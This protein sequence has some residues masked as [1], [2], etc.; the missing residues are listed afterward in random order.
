MNRRRQPRTRQRLRVRVEPGTINTVTGDLSPGGAFVYS[1]RMLQPGT[2]VRFEVELPGGVA[3][4]E[5]VVRWARRVPPHLSSV[6]RGG[7]GIEFTRLSDEL[8]AH[9]DGSGTL[10]LRAV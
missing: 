1:H 6:A 9:L 3:E 10:F 7:M 4:A 5:G 8:R 2:R